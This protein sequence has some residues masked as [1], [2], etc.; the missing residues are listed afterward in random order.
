MIYNKLSPS[1]LLTPIP[2]RMFNRS[3]TSTVEKKVQM[4]IKFST[5]ELHVIKFYITKLDEEYLVVLGYDWLTC[6]NPIIDWMETKIT[7]WKPAPPK[8]MLTTTSKVDICWVSAQTMTKLC[9][10][11][12]NT[13][14]AISPAPGTH[15]HKPHLWMGKEN[16]RA[17]AAKVVPTEPFPDTIPKGYLEF[18]KVFSG[19]KANVLAPHHLYDLRINLEE[20]AKPF[21]G[22]VYS[23]SP[24][25]LSTLREFLEE[26]T[27]YGFI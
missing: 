21:H 1:Y 14:F 8:P 6:H 4:P 27:R 20:G 16:L 7:S 2:L 5:S 26:N 24:P 22:P 19:K 3:S 11:L 23:L 17:R 10:D 9:W 25:K 15:P 12:G 13:M 18:C